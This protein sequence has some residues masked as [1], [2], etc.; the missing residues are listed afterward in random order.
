[1]CELK[2]KPAKAG[3]YGPDYRPPL[4]PRFESVISE[5]Y[6]DG[7]DSRPRWAWGLFWYTRRG[8][9]HTVFRI[10]LRFLRPEELD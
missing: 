1:M 5:D 6:R 4:G 10:K 8:R 3:Y 7:K 2:Y 9:I